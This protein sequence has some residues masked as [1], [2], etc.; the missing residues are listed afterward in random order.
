M[1]AD[2]ARV[3]DL[4][5]PTLDEGATANLTMIDPQA[6]W[7]VGADGF[8]SKSRNSAFLGAE[9]TG[10]VELTIAGGQ[11]AWQR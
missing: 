1:T 11:L 10:Q 9:L 5:V 8:Q 7:V 6:T 2:A 4:P 3:L